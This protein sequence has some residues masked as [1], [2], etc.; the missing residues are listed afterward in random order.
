MHSHPAFLF[1]MVGVAAGWDAAAIIRE[2]IR[3]GSF[4]LLPGWCGAC[5]SDLGRGAEFW[6]ALSLSRRSRT[7]ARRGGRASIAR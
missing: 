7:Y 6:W 2:Q 3:D 5:H 1:V 4:Q